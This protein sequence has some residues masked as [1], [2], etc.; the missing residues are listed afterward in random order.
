LARIS[1]PKLSIYEEKGDRGLLQ[2]IL[3][4]IV[5]IEEFVESISIDNFKQD[6]KTIFAVTRAFEII[7]E[8]VKN[9]PE[10]FRSKYPDVSWRAI[11]G[12]RDKLI[13]EYFGVDI[14]VLWETTQQDVPHL[15]VLIT[16]VIEELEKGG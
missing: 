2:D 7:G 8:A 16:R 5:A 4:A 1:W 6:R 13:H 11:A 14:D 3:D 12:M 9:I 10:F 15:K